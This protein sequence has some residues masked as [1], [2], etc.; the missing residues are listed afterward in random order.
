[1][2]A[3][4]LVGPVSGAGYRTQVSHM[5][6]IRLDLSIVLPLRLDLLCVCVCLYCLYVGMEMVGETFCIARFL[7]KLSH[8]GLYVCGNFFLSPGKLPGLAQ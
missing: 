1:M 8:V 7:L 3:L 2:L 6:S 5:Q 4:F